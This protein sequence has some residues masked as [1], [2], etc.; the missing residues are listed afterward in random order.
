LVSGGWRAGGVNTSESVGGVVG[1]VTAVRG[2][3]MNPIRWLRPPCTACT[4]TRKFL[5]GDASDPEVGASRVTLSA[6]TFDKKM[7]IESVAKLPAPSNA[8]PTILISPPA[9][10]FAGNV[11]DFA[12][13]KVVVADVKTVSVSAM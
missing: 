10:E 5:A 7:K 2:T 8:R 6:C 12:E 13:L 11:I 3:M 1:S 9:P 4:C